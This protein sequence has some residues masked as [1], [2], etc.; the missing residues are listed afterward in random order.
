MKLTN[1]L[2]SAT[3]ASATLASARFINGTSSFDVQLKDKFYKPAAEFFWD[4]VNHKNAQLSDS[5]HTWIMALTTDVQPYIQTM[6]NK[7]EFLPYLA[8]LNSKFP[9]LVDNVRVAVANSKPWVQDQQR[10][11]D[12][13]T[14]VGD[15]RTALTHFA[16]F[17]ALSLTSS[18]WVADRSADVVSKEHD[19]DVILARLTQEFKE[20]SCIDRVARN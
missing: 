11:R 20:G 1:A 9:D 8:Q 4:V 7:A 3:I 12:A 6:A 17:I 18:G 13:R 14:A 5:T 16:K 15:L 2:L 19:V 10:C